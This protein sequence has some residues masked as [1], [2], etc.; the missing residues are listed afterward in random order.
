M[1]LLSVNCTMCV[2]C[3]L[4]LLLR[5]PCCVNENNDIYVEIAKKAYST[6]NLHINASIY[7]HVIFDMLGSYYRLFTKFLAMAF[8]VSGGSN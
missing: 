1:G 4:E 2:D 5:S 6:Q 8:E 7:V 3:W